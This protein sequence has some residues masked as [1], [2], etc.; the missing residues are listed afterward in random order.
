[1]WIHTA[2]KIVSGILLGVG[3]IVLFNTGGNL[4]GA[5]IGLSTVFTRFSFIFSLILIMGAILLFIGSRSLEKIVADDDQRIRALGKG[6]LEFFLRHHGEKLFR[7]LR[8]NKLLPSELENRKN[9]KKY[10]KM[11][12]QEHPGLALQEYEKDNALEFLEYFKHTPRQNVRSGQ[13]FKARVNWKIDDTLL[14]I[15]EKYSH[16]ERI[17]KAANGKMYHLTESGELGKLGTAY[18]IVP[19]TGG[20]YVYLRDVGSGARVFLRRTSEWEYDLIAIVSGGQKKGDE[21]KVFDRIKELYPKKK[22]S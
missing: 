2:L 20:R 15:T 22:K 4:T 14:D 11:M 5:V 18:K 12:L 1:M 17:W 13:E 21:Q 7:Y 6:H 8:A 10:V 19:D 16:N 9:R 3:I